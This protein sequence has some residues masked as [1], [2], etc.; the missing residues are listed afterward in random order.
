MKIDTEIIIN[1]LL[2]LARKIQSYEGLAGGAEKMFA[3]TNLDSA[4]ERLQ[5]Q[6]ERIRLLISERDSARQQADQHWRLREE[7]Q[8]LLGTDDVAEGVK[9]VK[10]QQERIKRLEN[11]VSAALQNCYDGPMPDYVRTELVEAKNF[12][13]CPPS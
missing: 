12:T 8:A 10:A 5:E 7:F 4:A 3:V 11:A 13:P 9:R 2:I 1:A 6:Q